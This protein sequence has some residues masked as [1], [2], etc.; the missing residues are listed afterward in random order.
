MEVD[1]KKKK[2]KEMEVKLQNYTTF[3]EKFIFTKEMYF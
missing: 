3:K 2:E 1:V